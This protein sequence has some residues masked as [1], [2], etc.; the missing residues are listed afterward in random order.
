M[1]RSLDP[2]R[3]SARSQISLLTTWRILVLFYKSRLFC[4]PFISSTAFVF[5]LPTSV[6]FAARASSSSPSLHY[7]QPVWIAV[8]SFSA[9]DSC[10][11]L[12]ALYFGLSHCPLPVQRYVQSLSSLQSSTP[13]VFTINLNSSHSSH[14]LLSFQASYPHPSFRS[15]RSHP[16]L[17]PRLS[18]TYASSCPSPMQFTQP[19]FV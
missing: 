19:S 16:L 15:L 8:C 6:G 10:F 14:L 18:S 3:S 12:S 17:H 11:C 5:A 1:L 2:L 9:V 7:I 4:S 13:L